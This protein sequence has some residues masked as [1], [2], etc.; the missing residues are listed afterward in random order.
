SAKSVILIPDWTAASAVNDSGFSEAAGDAFAA[1]I[2]RLDQKL[3]G[4]LDSP[5]HFIGEGR[6]AVVNTEIMQRL[7]AWHSDKVQDVHST[8]IDPAGIAQPQMKFPIADYLSAAST[9]TTLS[10]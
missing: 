4:V 1:A 10:S 5:M 6:G 2:V 3:G 8:T 7:L 9:V